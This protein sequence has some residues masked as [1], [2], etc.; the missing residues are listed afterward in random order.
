MENEYESKLNALVSAVKAHKPRVIALQEIMQLAEN[1]EI[2]CSDALSLKIPL[3]KGN[4]ALNIQKKLKEQGINYNLYWLGF[5]KSYGKFDEGV[6]ILSL[7][8]A[9]KI[10]TVL[11]SPFED[12]HNWKTRMA[13]G[14]KIES[15]WYFSTHMG[16]WS[17]DESPLEN[18]LTVLFEKLPQGQVFLMGDFNSPANERNRGY[19]FVINNGY[20][21]TYF[22]ASTKDNGITAKTDIDG[23]H[24]GGE[25]VRIDYI[26][27]NKKTDI[28]SSFTIFNGKNE[29]KIS[30]HYGVMIEL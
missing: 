14:I 7:N 30:D 28:K 24:G 26:F 5:K 9:S 15:N 2:S 11:L 3:K 13:L 25:N 19:D 8:K 16:W 21:D 27:T 12:Y 20:F 10:S 4:H 18:E 6:A 17:D 22:L 29:R 1:G 23:W